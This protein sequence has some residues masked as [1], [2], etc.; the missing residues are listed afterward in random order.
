MLRLSQQASL[1][2][3]LQACCQRQLSIQ[4][5]LYTRWI[6]GMIVLIAQLHIISRVFVGE[7]VKSLA[8][9]SS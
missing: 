8:I 3:Q 4:E 6:D 1:R 9:F 5:I 7:S 2:I